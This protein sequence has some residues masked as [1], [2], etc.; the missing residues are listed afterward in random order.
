MTTQTKEQQAVE[1]AEKHSAKFP[2]GEVLMYRSDFTSMLA[3]HAQQAIEAHTAELV[4]N[5]GVMP[6]DVPEWVDEPHLAAVFT[7]HSQKFREAIAVL[8]AKLEQRDAEIQRQYA[9]IASHNKITR[10]AEAKLE[11]SEARVAELERDAARYRWW[12]KTEN[13]IPAAVFFR[14]KEAIDSEIDA[15]MKKGGGV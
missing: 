1:L 3:D 10:D 9:C 4:A 8:Q 15:A 6:P 13:D 11:Q 2:Y 14:G 12:C 7:E 5:A